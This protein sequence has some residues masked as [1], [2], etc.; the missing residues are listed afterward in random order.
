[1]E[2]NIALFEVRDKSGNKPHYKG[3]LKIGGEDHEFAVWPSKSG[4][5]FS[6]RYKPKPEGEKKAPPRVPLDD[7][8]PF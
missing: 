8:L 6:G 4:N 1:M 7:D 2:G 3:F 5:G